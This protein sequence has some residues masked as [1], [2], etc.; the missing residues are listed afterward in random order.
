MQSFQATSMQ[1]YN[2]VEE[3]VE[4]GLGYLH[5][6]YCYVVEGGVIVPLSQRKAFELQ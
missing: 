3:L 2:I 1:F 6:L 5:T 4:K